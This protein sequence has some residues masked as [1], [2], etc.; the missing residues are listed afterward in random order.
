MKI[1]RQLAFL[2]LLCTAALASAA[3]PAP[4]RVAI[5]LFDNV[6]NIDFTGPMQV[7]DVAGFE[8]VTVA[9]SRL[10]VTI[11]GGLKVLPQY[12]F[13]DAPQSDIILVPGGGVDNVMMDDATL[14]WIKAQDGKA[15]H[16]MSVCNG[17]F[18]LAHTS[19]LDGMTV[20]T[21]SGNVS[22]LRHHS[23]RAKVVRNKRVVDEGKLITTGGLSAGIDGALHVVAKLRG[24]GLAQY[25]AQ[26]IEYDW[27]PEGSYLPATYALHQLPMYLDQ[28]L[29]KYAQVDKLVSSAGNAAEWRIS[30]LLSTVK[31]PA[32][33]LAETS[34]LLATH[35]N[36]GKPASSKAQQQ[37]WAFRDDEGKAWIASAHLA[38]VRDKS[39]QHLLTVAVKRR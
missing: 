13:A 2:I 16:V 31:P 38:S 26:M 10:P 25:V 36:W 7:F 17:A 28:K 32:E 11:S 35:G 15:Q 5:L 1:F 21:T 3:A 37:E 19:L 20:T 30:F 22:S 12:T 34:A 4:V 14:N 18:I 8:V 33:L 23:P 9:A 6:E 39:A 27:R 29:A 24:K